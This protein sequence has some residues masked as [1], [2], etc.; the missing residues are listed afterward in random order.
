MKYGFIFS[1][2]VL[3]LLLIA[4]PAYASF[5]EID[6]GQGYTE[7]F[8]LDDMNEKAEE[9][10]F[11][12]EDCV[13][14]IMY[15]N[16][17]ISAEYIKNSIYDIFL[18]EIHLSSSYIKTI[19]IICV[20]MGVF[21]S[22]SADIQ[23]EEVKKATFLVSCATVIGSLLAS[24]NQ[25]VNI[26][27]ST[28]T[29]ISDIIKS[30][31][32]LIISLISA[33]GDIDVFSPV[34]LVVTDTSAVIMD[35]FVIPVIMSAFAVKTLNCLTENR[36]LTKMGDFL[37]F[38][39]SNSIKIISMCFMLWLSFE[40]IS[41]ETAGSLL[42]NTAISAIKIVPVVGG[43]LSGGADVIMGS[44][45][46]VKNGVALAIIVLLIICSFVPLIKLAVISLM[47]KFAAALVEPLGNKAITDMVD[48][49][50]QVIWLILSSLFAIIFMYVTSVVIML[51]SVG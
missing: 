10:D 51:C 31:I 27:S 13:I 36:M 45:S 12:F 1:L 37:V 46:A 40:R 9:Y 16:W 41:S 43:V 30:G 23:G 15:G 35:K 24:Y 29:Q 7:N 39:V 34:L 28:V 14:G 21:N 11:D 44:I 4:K 38:I 48:T 47:Y 3:L 20:I 8:S 25:C 50:G 6:D 19:I 22:I 26:F 49:F 17:Q 2:I 32:P 33:G 42:T 5:I 18:K